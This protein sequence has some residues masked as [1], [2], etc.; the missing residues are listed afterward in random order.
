[1]LIVNLLNKDE[2]AKALGI[3]RA[4]LDLLRK[5]GLPW[6]KVGSQVRFDSEDVLRWLKENRKGNSDEI[7]GDNG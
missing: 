7:G 5:E 4:T 6:L 3:S 2:M 1:M